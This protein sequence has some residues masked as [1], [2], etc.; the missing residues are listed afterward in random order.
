MDIDIKIPKTKNKKESRHSWNFEFLFDSPEKLTC[1]HEDFSQAYESQISHQ[2]FS[3][4]DTAGINSQNTHINNAIKIA[5][6]QNIPKRDIEPKRPWI[7]QSTLNLIK[8]RDQARS[9]YDSNEEKLLNSMIRK[10]AKS[11]RNQWLSQNLEDGNWQ[12]LKSYRRGFKPKMGR[13][14]NQEG[15]IVP[16]DQKAETLAEYYANI[17]WKPDFVHAVPHYNFD[18]GPKFYLKES[19][20]TMDELRDAIRDLKFKRAAG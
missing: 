13:I 12:A 19:E 8:K 11:D 14:K 20:I 2:R 1:F 18:M 5:G 3:D 7:S 17:Q 16:N 15:E 4:D 6:F 10:S 9:N